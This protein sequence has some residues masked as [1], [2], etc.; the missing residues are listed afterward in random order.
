MKTK[1]TKKVTKKNV[2][3]KFASREEAEAFLLFWLEEGNGIWNDVRTEYLDNDT[4]EID[5]ELI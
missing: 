5:A 2:V 1:T 3:L 4:T